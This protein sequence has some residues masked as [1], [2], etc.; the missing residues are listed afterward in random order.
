MDIDTVQVDSREKPP[1]GAELVQVDPLAVPLMQRPPP[2]M[3]PP[4]GMMPPGLM[5]PFAPM[6][7][8]PP[9]MMPPAK[10]KK[11]ADAPKEFPKE[12]EGYPFP[13]G[14][15]LYGQSVGKPYGYLD[16]E[17]YRQKIKDAE[18]QT[19]MQLAFDY[20]LDMRP[21]VSEYIENLEG[22][23]ILV[24]ECDDPLDAA[25][26]LVGRLFS[27]NNIKH[28][29]VKLEQLETTELDATKTSIVLCENL[30]IAS[31]SEALGSALSGF[32]TSGGL[33]YSFNNAISIIDVAF[34]DK[35]KPRIGSTTLDKPIE[36]GT[37]FTDDSET[38]LFSQ[39][40][41]LASAR[42]QAVRLHGLQRFEVLKKGKTAAATVLLEE[43]APQAGQPLLVKFQAGRGKKRGTVYHSLT[44]H[45]VA[46]V[47]AQGGT[48]FQPLPDLLPAHSKA[49]A[50]KCIEDLEKMPTPPTT[51]ITAW[52]TALKCGF[53]TCINIAL[54]YYPFLDSLF[55]VL[56]EYHK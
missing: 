47:G 26:S 40:A 25:D 11:F 13:Q 10:K 50:E 17:T 38:Q 52:K 48:S 16:T 7:F 4:P 19:T 1:N 43:T 55:S 53:P 24:V 22:H 6:L 21:K 2:V 18:K 32:V 35:L 46:K 31:A 41:S 27:A 56:S 23:E 5:P 30:Q 15:W 36:I 34:P 9:G 49:L 20:L 45:I 51:T 3:M 54:S 37:H 39:Y 44:T 8:P 29:R 14:G 33:I 28:N 12:G 42:R